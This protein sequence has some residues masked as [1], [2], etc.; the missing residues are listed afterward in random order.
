MTRSKPHA[1]GIPTLI[2]KIK[3]MQSM[4]MERIL[5]T[6]KYWMVTMLMLE[7]WVVRGGALD[8]QDDN[9]TL[10]V[11]TTS[12]H[13][14]LQEDQPVPSVSTTIIDIDDKEVPTDAATAQEISIT[15]ASVHEIKLPND[16][17]HDQSSAVQCMLELEKYLH[18]LIFE[19]YEAYLPVPFT[20]K[21]ENNVFH[22]IMNMIHIRDQPKWRQ[23]ATFTCN[24]IQGAKEVPISGGVVLIVQCPNVID[25]RNTTLS[26]FSITMN[27]TTTVAADANNA[28]NTATTTTTTTRT[29]SYNVDKFD[30]SARGK[31]LLTF[32]NQR[33][34]EVRRLVQAL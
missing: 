27:D 17:A 7:Q 9:S 31:T 5:Q 12:S 10:L 25:A 2:I 33:L 14:A 3:L 26:T 34:T 15:N 1:S 6:K 20:V 4:E 22:V 19:W 28:T 29:I 30:M 8:D 21:I 13:T 24:G 18:Q 11:D 32:Q 23:Q 16:N